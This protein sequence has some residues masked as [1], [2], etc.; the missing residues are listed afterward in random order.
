LQPVEAVK[1]TEDVYALAGGF[2]DEFTD[3]VVGIGGVAH[4]VGAPD[5]HLEGDVGNKPAQ[6]LKTTPGGFP[7]KPVGHVEGG[8]APHFQGEQV[9]GQQGGGGGDVGHVPGAHACGQQGLVG[10]PHGGVGQEKFF[11]A[12]D[13]GDEGLGALVEQE[14]TDAGQGVG[15]R[16][17]SVVG[18][19]E[20]GEGGDVEFFF[21]PTA[22]VDGFFADEAEDFGFDVTVGG[23]V[24]EFGSVVDEVGVAFAA[25]KFFVV[26]NVDKKG[27]VGFDAF[28]I[29]FF[30]GTDGFFGGAFEGAGPRDDFHQ[31]AVVE[32]GDDGACVAVAAVQAD[33][34]AGAGAVDVDAAGVG[35]EVGQGVF[36]GDAALD[37]VTP[38]FDGFLGRDADF[39]GVQGVALSDIDLALDNVDTCGHFGDGVFHLD[40]RVHFDEVV[41]VLAVHKEFDGTGVGVLNSA[42]DFKGVLMKVGSE[43]GGD[44]EGRGE[45]DDFLVAALDGA[46]SFVEVND[47]AVVVA[48]DL[49]FDV[50]GAFEVFFDEDVVDAEGFLGFAFGVLEFQFEV[51]FPVNHAHAPA[52]AAGGGFE[53][54]G[55][56]VLPGEG[57][58][59]FDVVQ[60]A[61]DAGNGGHTDAFGQDFGFDFVAEVFQGFGAGA[62]EDDAG[63]FAFLSE[64]G[65]F[66]QEAVSGMNGVGAFALS[67]VDDFFDVK[68]G[69]D[70]FHFAPDLIGFVRPGA[71]E[72][73]FVFFGVNG[74]GA[75][76]QFFAGAE[77][78]GSNFAAIGHKNFGYW[79]DGH[80]CCAAPF[81][82]RMKCC[83]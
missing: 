52:A 34:E 68:I 70:G 28:N 59:F 19:G 24:K 72:G 39:R 27:F 17:Q 9:L 47:V 7:Q 60:G 43:F 57:Q 18:W 73:V 3:D 49:D 83:L 42:G 20:F 40:A 6:G 32:G 74:N 65:V 77:D 15:I 30:D 4:G 35:G 82:Y 37:G 79:L 38:G 36:G 67:Q 13:P 22:F 10:V 76:S 81:G 56:A 44:A 78:S 16:G 12:V 41:P 33:A 1:Y 55:E 46:V 23:D 71:E 53:D 25:E 8:A 2:L 66:G 62:D 5:K 75:Y 61:G 31:Q 50:F 69:V 54:D 63:F 58:G 64:V 11:L 51:C 21:E 45:F 80:R 14:P 26:E 48:E 29:E